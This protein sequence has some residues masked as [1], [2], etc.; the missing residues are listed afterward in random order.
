MFYSIFVSP[1]FCFFNDLN[2]FPFLIFS[3]RLPRR[4]RHMIEFY[5]RGNF[6]LKSK[7]GI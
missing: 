5:P 2:F 3:K 4:E 6:H 7:A 1:P